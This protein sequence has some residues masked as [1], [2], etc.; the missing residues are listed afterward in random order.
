[1]LR[2]MLCAVA[3]LLLASSVIA[4]P[5]APM[6][7]ATKPVDTP[8][9]AEA[10]AALL[11]L[12]GYIATGD[13]DQAK[14]LTDPNHP[15]TAKVVENFAAIAKSTKHLGEVAEKKFGEEAKQFT[16]R[17]QYDAKAMAQRFE[18]KAISV[19][20]DTATVAGD[21]VTMQKIGGEWK[22]SQFST[23]PNAARMIGTMLPIANN[24][25]EEVAKEIEADKY[26]TFADVQKASQQK[27]QAAMQ[28]M[29][30]EMMTGAGASSRPATQPANRAPNGY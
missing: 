6:R 20:G 28:K 18:N 11:K 12:W 14:A 29:M 22:L 9:A 4:Q 2:N 17:N 24:I 23:D 19:N 27:M 15:E 16:S 26:A 3:C 1:M 21:G 5:A 8:E 13:V 7:P 10:R 30:G 25:M